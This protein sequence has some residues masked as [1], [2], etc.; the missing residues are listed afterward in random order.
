MEKY[1]AYYRVS[2]KGQGHTGLGLTAQKRVV[3]EFLKDGDELINQYQEIE[4]GK[5]SDRPK[6][7]DAIEECIKT[8][9]TLLI[10]KLDRLSRD[11]AF[12]YTLMNS[13]VK[14]KC[15]DMPEATPLTIGLMAVLAEE[16]AK[17]VS[18]RT[19]ASLK[20]I[21]LKIKRGEVH[22]SKTGKVVLSL[23]SPQNLTEESR[24]KASEALRNKALNNPD[25]KKAYAFMEVLRGVG[26][27]YDQIA[28]KLNDS[29]FK[30]PKGGK[31]SKGQV[32]RIFKMFNNP[33]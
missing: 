31:F 3:N 33:K 11:V 23:G 4:S 29:G 10:A 2:T 13:N 6:L 15:V 26:Y 22:I 32:I 21:K 8:G 24:K 19:K 30:A 12:I 20:S 27:T 28:D 9:S 17:R 18:E 5:K 25:T 7:I 1:I 14:F 16:E